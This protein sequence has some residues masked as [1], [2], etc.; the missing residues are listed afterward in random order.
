LV[1]GSSGILDSYSE[2]ER[3]SSKTS[4]AEVFVAILLSSLNFST[5]A[6][7]VPFTGGLGLASRL[8]P[9]SKPKLE[10]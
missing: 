5:T 2:S 3:T 9:S 1:S 7:F 8:G 4:V 6:S 10:G